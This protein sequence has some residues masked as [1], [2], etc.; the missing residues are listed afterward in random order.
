MPV[1]AASLARSSVTFTVPG[2]RL[3]RLT[4][5]EPVPLSLYSEVP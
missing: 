2:S 5:T 1:T 4:G 3:Y